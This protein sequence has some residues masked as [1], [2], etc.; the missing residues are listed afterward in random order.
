MN[1]L[2]FRYENTLKEERRY[3]GRKEESRRYNSSDRDSDQH[4]RPSD[5]DSE[6]RKS[7]S[8][9]NRPLDSPALVSLYFHSDEIVT[10]FMQCR[11]QSKMF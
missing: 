3:K 4:S 11:T 2:F 5:G 1:S 10:N 7:R 6:F 8:K 9:T